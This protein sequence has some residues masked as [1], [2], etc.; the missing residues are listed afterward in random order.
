[1]PYGQ[2]DIPFLWGG[3]AEI[4]KRQRALKE[5]SNSAEP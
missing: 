5:T 3:I 2:S 1:M 4:K